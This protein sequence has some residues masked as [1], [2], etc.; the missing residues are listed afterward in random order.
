MEWTENS[1][2]LDSIRQLLLI[3]WPDNRTVNIV[4]HGHSV[5]SGYYI[6]PDVRTFESYPHLLHRKIK[7]AYP[8]AVV[9]MI[10][11]AVGG[12]DSQTGLTRFPAALDHRPDVLIL[13]YCLNDRRLSL[14]TAYRSWAAMIE[15]ALARGI[16][17]ILMTPNFDNS[18]LRQDSDWDKLVAHAKQ[19]RRLAREY[20]VGLCDV[21][22]LFQAEMERGQSLSSLLAQENHPN[23]NGHSIVAAALATFFLPQQ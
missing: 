12:E 22:S 9:N 13:D 6:S 8:F 18:Y 21:F 14:E 7:E 15:M 16:K 20:S 11:S 23:L 4:C 17:M 1:A 10:L 2:Y 5:P 19:V 3:P